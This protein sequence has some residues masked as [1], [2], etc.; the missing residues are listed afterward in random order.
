[1]AVLDG[2]LYQLPTD[3]AQRWMVTCA[4]Q[5]QQERSAGRGSKYPSLTQPAFLHPQDVALSFLRH[6]AETRIFPG[7]PSGS[8][9][10]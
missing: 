6:N 1:M 7:L 4:Q 3:I 9:Q 5:P 8:L 10:L 2:Q